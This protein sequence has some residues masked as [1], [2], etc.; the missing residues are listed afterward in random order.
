MNRDHLTSFFPIWSFISFSCL[1]ALART[2]STMMN[3]I[4]RMD[5][6]ATFL[7]LEKI[8]FIFSMECNIS[9]GLIQPLVHCKK[10]LCSIHSGWPFSLCLNS[11]MNRK[12]TTILLLNNS[13]HPSGA[14]PT[15]R[16]F[17]FPLLKPSLPSNLC[18]KMPLDHHI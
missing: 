1:I 2:S 13:P 10:P 18:S 7:I 9:Y 16:A 4:V 5:I 17:T 11:P 15:H 3:R 6:L 14:H 8:V 12:L